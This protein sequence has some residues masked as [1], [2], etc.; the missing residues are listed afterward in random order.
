MMK[1]ESG[2]KEYGRKPLKKTKKKEERK[3]KEREREKVT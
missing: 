2:E 3:I 1:R